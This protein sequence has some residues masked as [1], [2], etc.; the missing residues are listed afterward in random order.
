[1]SLSDYTGNSSVLFPPSPFAQTSP[2][3]PTLSPATTTAASASAV[4]SQPWY[5]QSRNPRLDEIQYHALVSKYIDSGVT[6]KTKPGILGEINNIFTGLESSIDS[7][8][9]ELKRA[10]L[11]KAITE[12]KKKLDVEF[13]KDVNCNYRFFGSTPNSYG[14]DL[15]EL[16]FNIDGTV[17]DGG[18]ALLDTFKEL[19]T[20][21]FTDNDKKFHILTDVDDTL[22]PNDSHGT[23]ISGV[24]KSWPQKMPY[25]GVIE[26]YKQFHTLSQTSDY[27]TVLSATPGMI[28]SSR[29][30]SN[31][32][33]EILGSDFG[34]IQGTERK[35]VL[36]GQ[37]GSIVRT[38][39]K[40]GNW[41]ESSFYRSIAE[42]KYERFCQYARIFPERKFIWIGDSGQGDAIAGLMMLND[43]NLNLN[44]KV[45]IHQVGE[46]TVVDE[47]IHYFKTYLDLAEI[48]T[49]LGIFT[50][51]I[52]TRI[53]DSIATVCGAI[54]TSTATPEQRAIH[55]NIPVHSLPPKEGGRLAH[56]SKTLKSKH[57]IKTKSRTKNKTRKIMKNTKKTKKN[58]SK[59]RRKRFQ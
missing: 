4:Q 57:I 3:N 6:E 46:I 35:R 28:K 52:V 20:K 58:I 44:V 49:K 42:T 48:F 29:L 1:M 11:I 22:F 13:S 39:L 15:R 53:R 38:V 19:S 37:L 43:P 14:C 56:K 50:N 27:S 5:L 51:D 24:D 59:I 45:C 41:P 10:E 25:P 36:F 33:K 21:Y 26:F 54:T 32:L 9:D 23:Y 2:P 30:S 17:T 8:T 12:L 7:E 47:R 16:I 34:F 18:N 40:K 31:E 55:C